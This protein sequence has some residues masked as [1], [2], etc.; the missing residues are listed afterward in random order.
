MCSRFETMPNG[1]LTDCAKNKNNVSANYNQ[2][3]FGLLN[4]I[5]KCVIFTTS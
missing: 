3:Q 2:H 1:C 5:S 4:L